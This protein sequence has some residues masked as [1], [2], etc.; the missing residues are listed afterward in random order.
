MNSRW[1]VGGGDYLELVFQA[2]RGARPHEHV[3]RVEV[4]Q[5]ADYEFDFRALDA[6][7]PAQ[8]DVFIAF[9]ERFGNFKRMEL[10]QAALARGFS[11]QPFISE[12]ADVATHVVVGKNVFVGPLAIV[13]HG[14]RLDYNSVVHAGA[15]IGGNSHI[16]SSAWV[17]PGVQIGARV[18]VG[19]H[20]IIRSGAVVGSGVKV[21]KGA[22]LGWPRRYDADVAD[23]T[24]YDLRYDEPICVY[25]S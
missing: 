22:E 10:F 13:G 17:E 25:G 18:V 8:G 16:R 9:D 12:R 23:K 4:A 7:N 5:G 20:A 14:S 21:G 19:A 24:I 11:L 6:L 2:W 1:I 3:Q 15:N